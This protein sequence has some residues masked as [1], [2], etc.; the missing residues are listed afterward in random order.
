MALSPD[1]RFI[2]YSALAQNPSKPP[3]AAPESTNQR[4]YVLAAD[5]SGETEV[6]TT[7]TAIDESPMWTPDGSTLLFESNRTGTW[8]L[9]A[10]PDA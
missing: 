9:W 6:T 10:L 4:L 8:D 2:A 7:S 3:P 5:G 1:G